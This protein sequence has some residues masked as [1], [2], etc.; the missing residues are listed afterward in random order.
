MTSATTVEPGADVDGPAEPSPPPRPVRRLRTRVAGAL[1]DVGPAALELLALTTFVFARPVLASLGRSA[2]TFVTRGADWTDVLVFLVAVVAVPAFVVVAVDLVARLA[3]ERALRPVHATLVGVLAALAAWQIGEQV[4]SMEL[5]PLGGAACALVGL[6]VAAL[7]WRTQ[8]LATFLRY[9]SLIVLV[10]VGQF[11][12]TSNSGQILLG[13]RHVGVDAD[14]R[15]RVAAAVG[16]DGPPVV[17][18]VFDGLPTELLMDGGGGIDPELYP[19]LAAL[20]GTSTWYRNNTTVAPVTL[21]A[22]PAILSGTLGGKAEAPVASSYP[23]N[24]FTMLGGT[25]DLHALEPLTGL[26]PVSL[27]PAGG[28]WPVNDLLGDAGSVWN[29]QMGGQTQME[30]FVPGA[31]DHRFDRISAWLDQQD[32]SR[33][34]RPDAYVM[35]LL[36]PHDGWQYLPDG[37]QYADAM[38]SP[39]GMWAYTW[40]GVGAGVGRQ[41]HIMQMQLVDRIVGRVMDSLRAAGTFDDALMVVTADHGY[42][43][44][45]DDLVRGLT[46]DNFDQVMW[47]PL[48]VKS[49]GQA[50]GRVDDANVQTV[51]VLP[52]IAD[53]LGV[54]LPW[55]D[56]DGVPAASADRDP[57]DKAMADW[58]YSDLRSDDGSPVAVDAAEGFSRVLAGDAVAGHGP[59]ALWDRTGGAHGDLVGRRVDELP[60]GE[61][62]QQPLD[63]VGL[64][65]WDDVDPQRPPLEVLGYSAL[66]VDLSVAVAVNGTVAAVVPSEPGPYG[67]TAVDAL[68]WPESVERGDNAVEAFVVEGPPGAPTLR[69]LIVRQH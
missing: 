1:R 38:G 54:D 8:A 46:E 3:A 33:G 56:L 13:G 32:F 16:D 52:T 27:C 39:T 34:D 6:A 2:E 12:F 35:H 29:D 26:C 4:T 51:D 41:R 62:V 48:I 9:G 68:L 66:P 63:V 17:L 37:T 21:Q 31:F 11:A 60:L 10:V 22:V 7:R 50:A 5:L 57:D 55:D 65:R 24:V 36:L 61:G 14:V 28:G 18:M 67:T 64:D 43:F 25:Y 23:E 15:E 49:P 40:G 19:H 58:G 42:A 59:L 45:D 53:E 47:T 20:A 44:H 69:P 30:F